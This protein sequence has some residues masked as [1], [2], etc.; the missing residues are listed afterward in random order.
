[1]AHYYEN[2]IISLL[3]EIEEMIYSLLPQF[4]RYE[5]QLRFTT[6]KIETGL[7][8]DLSNELAVAS[9]S[10]DYGNTEGGE[11]RLPVTGPKP[12]HRPAR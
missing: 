3:N 10:R 4:E 1:M 2:R 7:P 11:S 5:G 6:G 9:A 12:K 8:E